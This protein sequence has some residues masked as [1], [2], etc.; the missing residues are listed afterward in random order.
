MAR[1]GTRG[2][3]LLACRLPSRR[4]GARPRGPILGEAVRPSQVSGP[5]SARFLNHTNCSPR[6]NRRSR[7]RPG[8]SKEAKRGAQSTPVLSRVLS[9]K[10]TTRSVFTK[11]PVPTHAHPPSYTFIR[12]P[13]SPF[14]DIEPWTG[15]CKSLGVDSLSSCAGSIA[16]ERHRSL[17]RASKLTLSLLHPIFPPETPRRETQHSFI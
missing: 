8:R 2:R 7:R 14:V 11:L 17:C 12:S 3:S 6:S 15:I 5:A 10:S 4:Q 9:L 1:R 16:F 13:L